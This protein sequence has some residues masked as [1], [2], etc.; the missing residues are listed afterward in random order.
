MTN[1]STFSFDSLFS[2]NIDQPMAWR[3]IKRATYDFAIAYPD[4]SSLPLD[5][6]Q[7]ALQQALAEEGHDL[8]LYQS[9]QGYPPLREFV[10]AKLARDRNIHVT[11]DDILLTGGA[12]Q[13]LHVL[14]EVLLDP[15]DIVFIDDYTYGGALRQLGRFKADLRTVGNDTE[16][17]LPD[18]LEAAIQQ[19]QSENKRPKLLYLIPT[20]QNPQGWTMSLARRKEILALAHRYGIAIVEDDCYSDLCYHGSLLPSLYELDGGNLVAYVNSFSKTIAPGMRTGYMTAPQPLLQRAQAAKSGGPVPLFVTLAIHRFVTDQL[21]SHIEVISDIQRQ[22]HDAMIAALG[23]HFGDGATW[24]QPGGGLSIWVTF[25]DGT[26]VGPMRNKIM[27]E[28]DVGYMAGVNYNAGGT[29][30][31]NQMRLTFGYNTPPEIH[32]GIGRLAQAFRAEGVLP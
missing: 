19:A 21:A 6:L 2:Q 25:P 31:H 18:Q 22:R 5:G 17:M 9:V 3:G 10:A 7:Q 29:K 27:D 13:A 32:E 20:F 4:P 24:S 16:G 30:G 11:A 26:D 1:Q 28:H 14:F 23:A 12:G 15:G 8:A